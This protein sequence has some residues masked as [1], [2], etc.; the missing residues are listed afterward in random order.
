MVRMV[1]PVG[2]STAGGFRFQF[3]SPQ[4]QFHSQFQIQ[5][6][7]GDDLPLAR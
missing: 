4:F 5:I 3:Q 6:S 2:L 1:G 7:V